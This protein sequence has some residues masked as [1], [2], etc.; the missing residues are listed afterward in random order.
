MTP[1]QT[2]IYFLILI[3]YFVKIHFALLK[4]QFKRYC[5]LYCS[6]TE[7]ARMQEARYQPYVV[8]TSGKLW[9]IGG[10]G[11]TFGSHDNLPSVEVYDPEVDIWSDAQIPLK[12]VRG[13]VVGCVF[14]NDI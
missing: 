2:G 12:S 8:A 7:V 10:C 13:S 6:W 5:F 9:A 4:L 3:E 1:N 14:S 11:H